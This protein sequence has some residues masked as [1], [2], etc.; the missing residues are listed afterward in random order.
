MKR[1]N[2]IFQRNRFNSFRTTI[3]NRHIAALVSFLFRIALCSDQLSTSAGFLCNWSSP[4]SISASCESS[5]QVKVNK[6]AQKEKKRRKDSRQANGFTFH[7]TIYTVL[8]LFSLFFFCVASTGNGYMAM[9]T[10][11]SEH[12][13]PNMNTRD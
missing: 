7:T 9:E 6:I 13:A 11:N 3:P 10:I 12:W 2:F 4:P 8:F 1:S 5:N